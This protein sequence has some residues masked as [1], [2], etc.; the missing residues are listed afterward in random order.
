[1]R[2]ITLNF[3]NAHSIDSPHTELL[4]DR[5]QQIIKDLGSSC[6]RPMVCSKE[7]RIAF[8]LLPAEHVK[9]LDV[10]PTLSIQSQHIAVN[11]S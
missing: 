2:T 7:L 10:E 8:E 11:V 6:R 1:M 9:L 4:R 3:P 5:P